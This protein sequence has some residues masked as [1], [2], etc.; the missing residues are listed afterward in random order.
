MGIRAKREQGYC[1]LT[2]NASPLGSSASSSIRALSLP[3]S[4]S[5]SPFCSGAQG[6]QHRQWAVA[7]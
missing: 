7:G 4:P 6:R 5:L 3:D 1:S 2:K